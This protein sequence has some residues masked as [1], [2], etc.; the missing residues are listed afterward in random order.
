MNRRSKRSAQVVNGARGKSPAGA[1][2]RAKAPKPSSVLVSNRADSARVPLIREMVAARELP[3]WREGFAAYDWFLLRTSTV[4]YGLGVSRGDGAPVITVPGFLGTDTY[5]HDMHRWLSRIG[6]RPFRSGIGRNADCP[7]TLLSRLLE[8]VEHA[9][10]VTGRR[11][12][13][14]GHSLGGV[15]ARSAGAHRPDLVASVITLA[16]PFR[17]IRSHPIV[18]RTRTVVKRIVFRRKGDRSLH[19]DCYSGHCPCPFVGALDGF[20]R[21]VRQLAIYSRSDGIVD[22]R[23]CVTGDPVAD[24]EV[25]GTHIGLAHNPFVYRLVSEFLAL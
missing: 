5:L 3:I 18:L 24:R 22:W 16:A 21:D 13:L 14:I 23:M 20:P 1:T 25:L 11:V 9:H 7:N 15:L 4:F 10:A 8:R 19:V 2:R 6:Y 17:G 12:H